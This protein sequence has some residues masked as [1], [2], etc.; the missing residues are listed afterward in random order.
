M[1]PVSDQPT[2]VSVEGAYGRVESSQPEEH[3]GQLQVLVGFENGERLWVPADKL[4][5][6]E[7]GNFQLTLSLAE[8]SQQYT[9][10]TIAARP[11]DLADA[12]LADAE[13]T[14]Q[15]P[16]QAPAQAAPAAESDA[17][18]TPDFPEAAADVAELPSADVDIIR[19]SRVVESYREDIGTALMREAVDIHRVPVNEYVDEAPPIR[20]EDDRIIIP[21]L[22]EVLH[23]EKRLL[24]KEEVVVTKRRTQVTAEQPAL[25]QRTH[26]VA[27]PSS[28]QA[29]PPPSDTYRRHFEAQ[30]FAGAHGFAYYE[31]AYRFG[32]VLRSS[33]RYRGWDW[34]RLEPEARAL[35]ERDN[36][37]TWAAIQPAVR[38]AWSAPAT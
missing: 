27:E 17:L 30:Q 29:S 9:R 5:L 34:T 12:P 28:D 38:F 1:S 31:P 35:W 36:P 20:Y 23:V 3:D 11:S 18:E 22:E 8:L 6:Q 21:V 13:R 2:V 14:R 24:V 16:R 32:E 19:V 37:G 15:M 7:D 25:R 4:L 26:V 10:P 33:T